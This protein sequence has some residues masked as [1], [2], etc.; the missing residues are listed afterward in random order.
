M[1]REKFK[2]KLLQF[3]RQ[4]ITLA[5]LEKV[6]PIKRPSYENFAAEILR[7]EE[8][9]ILEI[10]KSKGRNNH[11]LSL[12]YHYRINKGHL[13]KEHHRKIQAYHLKCHPTIRLDAY[14]SLDDTVWQQDLPYIKKINTYLNTFGFPSDE[15]PAPE[16]S[17]E[18]VQDEK[19]IVEGKGSD[20][21]DRIDLWEKLKILPVSDPLM[22]A[23]HPECL[24]GTKHLHL[25]VENKT[26]Y[27][28]LL[29]ALKETNFTT[30]I[31]GCGNKIVKSIENFHNQLPIQGEHLFYYF[32]DLDHSG[33]SIWH[34]LNKRQTVIPA[35]AF[36]SACLQ[37]SA[38]PGKTNQRP[39]ELALQEFLPYFSKDEEMQIRDSLG[40]GTY[41]PQEILKTRDL[42]Q[43]WRETAWT[44]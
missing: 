1:T 23:L 3:D 24:Q 30:L 29:P 14:F 36:Y 42:Q 25:I 9:G 37:K 8:E 18:L 43:I 31:Y 32:G 16:R 33:I 7:L 15:V 19:W 6:F 35:H 28:A 27:Q 39:R 12:A 11:P 17:F 4:T 26:T 2:R 5:E 44:K 22:F 13:K 34:S 20:L 10:V 41:Y 40:A 21:L 38:V